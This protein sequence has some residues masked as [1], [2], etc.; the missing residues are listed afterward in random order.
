[1]TA[2]RKVHAAEVVVNL[3]VG[4]LRAK[5]FLGRSRNLAILEPQEITQTTKLQSRANDVP[6]R[7]DDG[8]EGDAFFACCGN[9]YS[10][11]RIEPQ[12]I[13]KHNESEGGIHELLGHVGKGLIVE[14]PPKVRSARE[15]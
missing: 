4:P 1:M 5:D 15:R 2:D 6:P 14:V 10:D 13:R 11:S 3:W 8:S 12:G 9:A 7:L